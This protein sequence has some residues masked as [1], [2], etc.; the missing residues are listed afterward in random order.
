[1]PAPLLSTHPHRSDLFAQHGMVA[2]T[3]PLAAQAGLRILLAGGNAADAA[4]ATAAALAVVEPMSTGIGGDAFAL[5]YDAA[6]TPAMRVTALNGSGRAPQ[7]LTL[8][9][10][11]RAGAATIALDSPH[12]VTVPGTVAAW[13]DLLARHGSLSLADVL[14]PAIAYARD[15]FPVSPIIAA[16]WQRLESKLRRLPSGAELLPGG[17]APRA[18]E[19]VR[20]PELAHTLQTLADHGPAAFYTG[21]IAASIAAFVQSLGGFL[22]TADLA[23]HRSTWD[24]PLAVDYRGVRVWECPPNGQGLAALLALNILHNDDLAALPEADRWHLLIEAQRLALADARRWVADPAFAPLPLAELLD[25]AYAAVRRRLIQPDRANP[26]ARS[27]LPAADR[28]PVQPMPRADTVYL[29]VV[30]GRGNACSWINSLYHGF[31]SGLVAPGTGVALQNRGA[32]FSLDPA[33]P[34]HLAPGKR[35]YHTIIPALVTQDDALWASFGVMGGFMQPQGHVQVLVN[36]L[37]LGL[38]PQEA[39]DAPRFCLQEGDPAGAV[40]I[41]V[42]AGE[43]LLAALH[44]KGHTVQP[45]AGMERMVF[46]AGQVIRRDAATGVLTGGSE[47][48]RDGCAVGW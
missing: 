43:A 39:L 46:G 16:N 21:D 5:Y 13:A 44:A 8:A 18:G 3:Q 11:Q 48:R 33:H 47:S 32:L 1:M 31:G 15:G 27:G 41:E 45:T 29:S 22:S 35:P 20:L 23:A 34:N 10:L 37:D 24:T 28:L 25:P 30:D 38:S 17:R 40:A 19:V 2:T 4:V 7:G 42:Q 26:A 12:S 36:L 14:Q 9:A 6:A